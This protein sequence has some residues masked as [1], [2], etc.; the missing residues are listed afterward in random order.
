VLVAVLIVLVV[1]VIATLANSSSTDTTRLQTPR[2]L[3]QGRRKVTHLPIRPL[4]MTQQRRL[5]MNLSRLILPL[6][7]YE[8]QR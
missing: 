1:V 6:S 7:H 8:S 4:L 5:G 3:L 2:P